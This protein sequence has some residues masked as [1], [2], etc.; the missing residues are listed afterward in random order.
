MSENE[1]IDLT[2]DEEKGWLGKIKDSAYENWQTILVA[3]VVLIVGVSAYNYNEKTG[4]NNSQPAT[5]QTTESSQ[6]TEQAPANTDQEQNVEKKDEAAAQQQDQQASQ[7]AATENKDAAK[8]VN[9]TETNKGENKSASDETKTEVKNTTNPAVSN[10]VTA[11]GDGYKTVAVKGDGL[12]H[13]ARKALNKYLEENKDDQVT[14]LHK[15]YIEDYLRKQLGNSKVGIKVGHEETFSKSTIEK[16]VA[17]SKK[18]SQKSLD[19]LKK[20]STVQ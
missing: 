8:Q 9:P 13:L 12:T 4:V 18:L 7:P 2:P 17:S 10:P 15:I 6:Q 19:N 5:E 14:D 11:E 1:E 20:Y 16:A 3:L